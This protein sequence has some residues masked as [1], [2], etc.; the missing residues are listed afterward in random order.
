[1]SNV[2]ANASTSPAGRSCPVPASNAA[3]NVRAVPTTVI[4]F[5]VTGSRPRADIRLSAWR[6]TQ[7][8][9]RVVN[10]HLLEHAGRRRAPRLLV[11][12][13]DLGRDRGPRIARRLGEACRAHPRPKLAVAGENDQRGAELGPTL[14][15]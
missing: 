9:N 13:D 6:R 2:P 14:R 12:L 7:A 3:R 4:W 11:Y 1:M 8:S 15:P 5:G 10:M